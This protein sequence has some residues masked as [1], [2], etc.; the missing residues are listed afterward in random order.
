[1]TSMLTSF[2]QMLEPG[3][4]T[5]FMKRSRAPRHHPWM[6]ALSSDGLC[7]FI[8]RWHLATI[9]VQVLRIMSRQDRLARQELPTQCLRP[10]HHSRDLDSFAPTDHLHILLQACFK[11]ISSSLRGSTAF[12]ATRL[13][14]NYCTIRLKSQQPLILH[15][16][17]ATQR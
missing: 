13:S 5:R 4:P 10:V 12:C 7:V 9:R 17:V 6:T 1:M 15:C 16:R 14:C 8:L 11:W 3:E 2:V